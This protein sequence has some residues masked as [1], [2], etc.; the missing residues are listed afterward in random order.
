M[1]P[2]G[3]DLD[4]NQ[5]AAPPQRKPS[6]RWPLLGLAASGP[7][8]AL[9][10]WIRVPDDIDY[11]KSVWWTA[12]ADLASLCFF[13][14]ALASAWLFSVLALRRAEGR[15]FPGIV[16]LAIGAIMVAVSLYMML[17]AFAYSGSVLE[18]FL[19]VVIWLLPAGLVVTTV[20]WILLAIPRSTPAREGRPPR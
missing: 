16:V 20:G 11:T 4:R 1:P 15:T 10:I 9:A 19:V 7:L 13:S 12:V 2:A 14:P 8:V 18:I 17:V 3:V 6:L 5:S